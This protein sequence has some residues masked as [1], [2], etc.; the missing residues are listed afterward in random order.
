[1]ST[2][3]VR[4]PLTVRVRF[5]DEEMI[6][7]GIEFCNKYYQIEQIHYTRKIFLNV[8][9]DTCLEYNTSID[10][11]KKRLYYVPRTRKWY[12]IKTYERRSA[13]LR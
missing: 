1:M 2:V 12:S 13:A 4:I 6:P 5:T 8:I 7:Y 9:G 10:G 11:H 3:A